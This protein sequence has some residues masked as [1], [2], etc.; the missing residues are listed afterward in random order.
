MASGERTQSDVESDEE[1]EEMTSDE[2]CTFYFKYFGNGQLVTQLKRKRLDRIDKMLEILVANRNNFH[3]P[4][5]EVR[6]ILRWE[7]FELMP[8]G[9]CSGLLRIIFRHWGQ[10]LPPHI[11]DSIMRKAVFYNDRESLDTLR[12]NLGR[13]RVD[14]VVHEEHEKFRSRSPLL[15]ASLRGDVAEVERL[16]AAGSSTR[17]DQERTFF[18]QFLSKGD[19]E[20]PVNAAA[21]FGHTAVADAILLRMARTR[22]AFGILQLGLENCLPKEQF[23]NSLQRAL[24]IWDLRCPFLGREEMPWKHTQ[25][26]WRCVVSGKGSSQ[27]NFSNILVVGDARGRDWATTAT[28]CADPSRQVW[29]RQTPLWWLPTGHDANSSSIEKYCHTARCPH[30]IPRGPHQHWRLWPSSRHTGL[31]LACGSSSSCGSWC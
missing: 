30:P 4:L 11:R 16:L 27:W 17:L 3:S 24:C 31:P 15:S 2:L 5:L 7:A 9:E 14:Q 10:D 23:C 21:E 19:D 29:R 28:P 26:F 12:E 22:F 18:C 13:Q 20:H 8:I 1:F 25:V 6:R